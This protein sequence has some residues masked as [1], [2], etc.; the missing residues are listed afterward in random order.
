[1]EAP[2]PVLTYEDVLLML[3][4][5]LNDEQRDLLLIYARA[6]KSRPPEMSGEEAFRL[7]EELAFDP[8]EL[9]VME[10]AINE[11]FEPH[12]LAEEEVVHE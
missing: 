11:M 2:P 8:A 7:A 3:V 12:L 5:Q 10:Q 1:M 9:A 4:R 6:L